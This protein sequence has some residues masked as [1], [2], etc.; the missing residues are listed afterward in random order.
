LLSIGVIGGW[1]RPTMPRFLSDIATGTV[2]RLRRLRR[3]PA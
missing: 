3:A 1:L 2:E